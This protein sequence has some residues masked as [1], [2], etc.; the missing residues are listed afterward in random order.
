M[1]TTDRSDRLY[2]ALYDTI[3]KNKR[4]MTTYQILGTL[5]VIILR[6]AQL[7]VKSEEDSHS[8]RRRKIGAYGK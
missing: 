4:G 5:L 2:D 6:F 7:N 3:Q 1:K 8:E